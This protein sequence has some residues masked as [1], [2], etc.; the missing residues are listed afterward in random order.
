MRVFNFLC[1]TGI[2]FTLLATVSF[3]CQNKGKQSS[4]SESVKQDTKLIVYSGRKKSLVGPLFDKFEETTGIDLQIKYGKTSPLAAA[5][6][7][8]SAANMI[9]ADI[10][11]AQDAG[12][13]GLL[14]QHKLL[15]ELPESVLKN[16]PK[17]FRAQDGTWIGISG[18]VRTVVYNTTKVK[19]EDLP[20]SLADLTLPSYKGRVG[21]A[22]GNASF[23]AHVTA[24]RVLNG[25]QSTKL[26]LQSM[27]TQETQSYPKNTP[28]VEAVDRGE[29][30]FG[31]VN[32]YY[33]HKL[34]SAGKAQNVKNH[35]LPGGET[36]VN[37]AGVALLKN[38][39][40][41]ALKLVE[42]LISEQAQEYFAA[43]TFEYPL[44]D[45]VPLSQDL[46]ALTEI[47]PAKLDLSSIADLKGSLNLLRETKVLR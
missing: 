11:F 37:V 24:L 43:K 16:I 27:M 33:L 17:A 2:T 21:W 36:I 12:G 19:K 20:Q 6:L 7:E 18:R 42:F 3:G 13:L 22:P 28:I 38:A 39:S 44:V 34:K 46:P 9:R 5:I 30:D 8:E 15:K 32:H 25:E 26:W 31:L 47:Q 14:S 41:Q 1:K 35:Y 10:F 23:Q 29:I 40:P 4:S 45:S